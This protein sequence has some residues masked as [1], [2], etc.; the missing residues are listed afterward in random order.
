MSFCAVTRHLSSQFSREFE[1]LLPLNSDFT[2]TKLLNSLENLSATPNL[3]YGLKQS[4][5]DFSLPK[6]R[7]SFVLDAVNGILA[8]VFPALVGD[9][10]HCDEG[11]EE[12][13]H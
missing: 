9:R 3:S 4:F 12:E 1:T 5:M 11:D 10:Q 6:L 7:F 8:G 2:L 13:G